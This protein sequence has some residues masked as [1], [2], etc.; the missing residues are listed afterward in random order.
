LKV[1]NESIESAVPNSR[2][3]VLLNRL[4][5]KKIKEAE[6]LLVTNKLEKQDKAFLI[7][8]IDRFDC[9]SCLEKGIDAIRNSSILD[10]Y[11]VILKGA[12]DNDIIYRQAEFEDKMIYDNT[13]LVLDSYGFLQTPIL[14]KY[15]MKNGLQDLLTITLK[16]DS[17]VLMDF[18]K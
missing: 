7:F 4:K 15:S 17:L 18:L 8:Y 12:D 1:E 9:S 2:R 5:N 16:S 6:A 10:D 11:L 3:S 14:I 13:D